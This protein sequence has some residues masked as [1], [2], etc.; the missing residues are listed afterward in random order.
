VD[1]NFSLEKAVE[2]AFE[3]L[4]KKALHIGAA[5]DD[6]E[7]EVVEQLQFNMVRG[8]Y[9]AGRNIRVKVQVKPGLIHEYEDIARRLRDGEA[10]AAG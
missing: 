3:L 1:R 7:M 5:A 6:L 8:F 10:P 9:T 4:R 2:K